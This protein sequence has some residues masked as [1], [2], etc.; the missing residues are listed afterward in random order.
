MTVGQSSIVHRPRAALLD[1]IIIL[2]SLS[3]LLINVPFLIQGLQ[4]CKIAFVG[5]EA[6]PQF[7]SASRPCESLSGGIKLGDGGR[8]DYGSGDVSSVIANGSY[9][10]QYPHHYPPSNLRNFIHP[11]F[12]ETSEDLRV[13]PGRS[14]GTCIAIA[15]SPRLHD[16]DD[17]SKFASTQ[18]DPRHVTPSWH[19]AEQLLRS[20][21][22]K[23]ARSPVM[24]EKSLWAVLL[25]SGCDVRLPA[26]ASDEASRK[27]YVERLSRQMLG[28]FTP[29][30]V[31]SLLD[32]LAQQAAVTSSAPAQH[33]AAL[34]DVASVAAMYTAVL[35]SHPVACELLQNVERLLAWAPPGQ[36]LPS[37][38]NP[39]PLGV[40]GWQA[41]LRGVMLTLD[42]VY[43]TRQC[44]AT[45]PSYVLLLQDDVIPAD[46]WDTGIE[47]F[48]VRDLRDRTPWTVLSLSHPQPGG[49]ESSRAKR[50]RHGDEYTVTP[51]GAPAL[52][53]NASELPAL[54]TFV[55][56]HIAERPLE[57]NL[58]EYLVT[59]G[60]K[61][62]THVPSLF[63][64]QASVHTTADSSAEHG[65]RPTRRDSTSE[66]FVV[67]R[68]YRSSSSQ[69]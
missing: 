44:L 2:S 46:Q 66:Q 42:F 25:A 51:G 6:T 7:V 55:E 3:V 60:K 33:A 37:Q 45:S 40:A 38:I 64:R 16:N 10:S 47:R 15:S 39:P 49:D 8:L 65:G 27:E 13:R 48:I 9:P 35:P 61:G 32:A 36:I 20:L 68:P 67:E 31:S 28:D 62:Y 11:A 56:A 29:A 54:L 43:V 30:S 59:S 41:W 23:R 22:S 18:P 50:P 5:P 4:R 63:Q 21:D 58:H 1:F 69:S 17:N 34:R 53:F 19:Y 52:L 57:L 24:L 12:F 14:S 26:E